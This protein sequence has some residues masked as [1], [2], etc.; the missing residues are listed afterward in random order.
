MDGVADIRKKQL[1]ELTAY[2]HT[3]AQRR[4]VISA[5]AAEA[6][7]SGKPIDPTLDSVQP[8]V[9]GESTQP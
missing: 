2:V 8:A 5:L 6:G 7:A 1:R 4:A 3:V 9:A